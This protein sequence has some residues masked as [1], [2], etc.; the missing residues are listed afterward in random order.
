MIP[1][2]LKDLTRKILIWKFPLCLISVLSPSLSRVISFWIF[3]RRVLIEELSIS[4]VPW[5][6]EMS[7]NP[8]GRGASAD[9]TLICLGADWWKQL[10]RS[11]GDTFK[12]LLRLTKIYGH[13]FLNC[14]RE[15]VIFH[16]RIPKRCTRSYVI[17]LDAMNLVKCH[18]D[19]FLRALGLVS[20]FQRNKGFRFPI[21]DRERDNFNIA[22]ERIHLFL[23]PFFLRNHAKLELFSLHFAEKQRTIA[24]R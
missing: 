7:L 23:F 20:A 21:I 2:W 6:M 24:R 5:T 8:R 12:T 11:R 15:E 13:H 17:L 16:A 4:V 22:G 14:S 3:W 19:S 10:R 18:C 9:A 1:S